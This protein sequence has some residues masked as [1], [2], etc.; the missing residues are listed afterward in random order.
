MS[1][2]AIIS[3]VLEASPEVTAK[4]P[5][6]N[7]KGGRLGDGATLPAILLRSIVIVDR[8]ALAREAM[9]RST[10]RVS[11]TVRAA[12]YR[13]QKE[14]IKL[15][16]SAGTGGVIA[17]L[18]DARSISILTAGAGPE[19]NGPGNSFERS[20]DFYVSYDAPA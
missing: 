7:M 4:V 13:E 14:I 16:R 11:V 3:A 9:V 18:D 6:D 2:V 19:L 20:Q 17:A 12:S 1:G 8:Q 5:P 10:E 15:V